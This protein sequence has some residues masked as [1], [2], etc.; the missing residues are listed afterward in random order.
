[1][2][3]APIHSPRATPMEELLEAAEETGTAALACDSVTSA[4]Q[5]AREK[6]N[7]GLVVVSGS[8]YLVGEARALLLHH[9]SSAGHQA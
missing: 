2:V 4:L 6:A 9:S 3:F 5:A 7:G 8:V 1:M